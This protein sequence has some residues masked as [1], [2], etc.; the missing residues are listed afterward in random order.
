MKIVEIIPQLHMGGAEMFT[1]NLCNELVEKGHDVTLVVTNSL[2]KYG[3][4]SKFVDARINLISM[5][6]R[7]GA[8]FKLF[9]RLTKLIKR[10]NPD[11]VHT[12]LGAILY[13]ILS[14]FLFR[15]IKFFHTIHNEAKKEAETGGKISAL[16]RKVLFR[17]GL[18]IPITISKESQNS[19]IKYYGNKVSSELILNG[20]PVVGIDKDNAKDDM[21]KGKIKLV[22]VARIQPQKNQ[23]ELVK[24]IDDLNKHNFDV[25]LYIV[26][27]DDTPEASR[28]RELN[29]EN[30]TLLGRK[31]NPRDYIAYAD[32][33][34]LS[35][36]YEGL[37]LTLIECFAAGKIPIC[38]PVGGIPDLVKD[39]VNGLLANGT[40]A[41][42][43]ES[44]IR[45]F[46]ALS[47]DKKRQMEIESHKS[48]GPLTMNKCA[49]NY[50]TLFE[51]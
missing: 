37:P 33:F 43:L 45:K 24:A 41:A 48:F 25:H 28:I 29:S 21:S 35:S 23:I 10:L 42:D 18:T 46:L 11:V 51:R 17:L 12:H 40:T 19:F 26:G 44:A 36:E 31:L 8:D 2:M 27:A 14:P 1:V 9:F 32:A 30:T 22:N 13:N 4:F 49:L 16:A 5:D 20:V 3:H 39:G 34:I 7:D 50:I 6:K 47:I 38:T 15:N